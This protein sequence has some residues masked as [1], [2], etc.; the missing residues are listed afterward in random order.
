[1]LWQ[2]IIR[3]KK[4]STPSLPPSATT[5]TFDQGENS[6]ASQGQ[7][8]VTDSAVGEKISI[9]KISISAPIIL[10]IDGNNMQAYLTALEGGVAHM[11]KTALPGESGNSVIFGHSSYYKAKPGSYKT[12]FAKLNL[13]TAGD[14]IKVTRENKN[15]SYKIL[16]TKI[17]KPE[18]ISVVNQDKSKKQLTLI[19]CWPP[20]TTTSRMVVVANLQ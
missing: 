18:D 15:Y 19:T 16:E 3:V 17:V 7:S 5:E 12:V 14:T 1:M 10:N 20:K 2:I 8:A 9:D 13:L 11:A 4:N 6:D